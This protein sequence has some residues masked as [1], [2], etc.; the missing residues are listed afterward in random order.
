MRRLNSIYQGLILCLLLFLTPAG[1]TIAQTTTLVSNTGETARGNS[2]F[3]IGT[4]FTTGNNSTGY[5][6]SSVDIYI[7]SAAPVVTIRAN[8]TNPTGTV[9]AT[10]TKPAT[11]TN[12]A[13][14]TYTAPANTVLAA[15]TTYWLRVDATSSAVVGATS[16]NNETGATGW[17]IDNTS[18]DTSGSEY[19]Q[20]IRFAITGTANPPA[21]DAPTGLTATA[22][23]GQVTLSWENPNN[24]DITKYQ[25]HIRIGDTGANWRGWRTIGTSNANTTSH[26]VTGLTNGQVY[27]FVVRARTG[28]TNGPES[29]PYVF[30]T[31]VALPEITIAR[32][33][34][35]AVT[36][37]ANVVFRV[38]ASCTV[39]T[40]LTVNLL[41]AD[42]AGA[43]FISS[44]NEEAQTVT[45]K[46][47]S[48]TADFTLSTVGDAT[49]EPSLSVSLLLLAGT[50]Y[51]LGSL[52]TDFVKVNDDDPTTVILSIPDATALE[53]SSTDRATVRLT[54][55]RALRARERLAI[56]LGFSNGTL[57]TDFSLSLSGTP[58]GVA[59]S[60][61][62][63]TFSG[64]GSAMMAEVLLSASS[65]ADAAE[66]TITVSIPSSSSGMAPILTA[67]GLDGGATG[68]RTGN[69]QIVLN[70][71]D[72]PALV[73]LPEGDLLVNEGE[74][75][76][77]FVS[78]ATQPT[79]NVTV[80]VSSNNDDVTVDINGRNTITFTPSNWE[81]IRPVTFSGREDDDATN[82]SA[83]LSHSASGGGYGSVTGDL[84]VL[85]A[86]NDTPALVFS[87]MSLTVDEGAGGM[88]TVKLATQPTANVTVMVS[89]AGGEVTVDTNSGS[90]GDQ[91]ALTF[92]PSDWNSGKT[93]TVSAGED[94]DATNDSATL[95]HSASGGDYGSVTGDVMVTVTDNDTP[96]LVFS[97]TSLTLVE[98]ASNTYTVRL[99]TQPTGNVTVTV[100]GAGG[101]VTVDTDTGT[102]G[103][104][105]TLS[106]TSTT[107]NTAQTVTVSAGED[108]DTT[109][110]SATLSHST[111]G[112]D[113][114]SVMGDVMVTVTDN[115]APALVFSPTSLTVGEGASDTYTVRL[116]IRPTANVTVR[117]SG[118]GG[119]IT[120]D[121]DTGTNGNQ[122]TLSF[123][124]SDW[125]SE[126]TVTVSAGEDDDA[127]NDSA[128]LS[129]SASGGGYGSVTGDVM[130]TV[131]DND[132]PALVFS[133]TSLTVDEGAGGMYTVK[134]AT[135]P[136]ANVTVMVSG[137]SGEVTVDTDTGTDGNQNTLSFT[138]SDWNS[139]K[140]VTVS[141]GQDDDGANDGATLTH[142]A[143][144]GDYG[145]VTGDVVVT[146]TDND[147]P[148]LVF[149]ST[150]LTVVE[151][152]SN[153]YTVRLAT[154]PTGNVTV[155][156]SGASGEVTVDTNTGT[157]GN[158]NTL[159]F[160]TSDW[161][162]EK[163][164]TVSAGQD[165]DMDNDGA[166]LTH[167]ATGGDY[168]SVMGDVMVTVTDDDAPALA[169]SPTSLTVNE[170]ASVMYTVRLA[171]QPTDNVTVTV[172]STSGEVTVDTDTGTSG[173]Q[174]TLSFTTSD[175]NSGKMVTVSAGEDD[176]AANDSAT[177]THTAA[178]GDYGSVTGD[179]MVTV[180][181]NDVPALVLS[182]T[183]LTVDEG[184]SGM[185]TVKL[186]TQPTA[187]V[188]VMVSGAS[189]EVTVDTDT[190]TDGNQNTLSFTT[191]DWNSE[192]TVTVSA[193]QD[194][195]STDDEVTLTHT[196]AGG[197]YGAVMGDV[198]VTVTDNDTPALVFTPTSLTVG[199]GASNTYTVKLATQPTG[200]V[201]VRVS[202]ASGEVTVDTDTGTTGDQNTLSFTTS[203]WNRDK[204]V[205]VSAGQDEDMDNDSAT[206][207][208]SA[209]GGDYGSVTGDVM[210]TV[211]DDD[212][213]PNNAP[214]VMTMIPDQTATVGAAFNYQFPDNTFSDADNDPLDY[215]ATLSDDS[216]LPG[217]LA[218]AK[219]T[220]TFSG[221]PQ[222]SNVGTINIKVT[223]DDGNGSM[224]SDSFD[225]TVGEGD[226]LL[227]TVED[228]EKVVIF[229]NPS[230]RYLEVRSP[231]G[232]AF[233][234]LSLSGKSL[235]EGTTNTKV[236]ITSLRSGLYL[237]QLSDGRLLKFVRE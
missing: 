156:V 37:G 25:Y 180:T 229:P 83:T 151:G 176:D 111:S 31:P 185:Y 77:Y 166:T 22:C 26:T 164:V 87:S 76:T 232:S 167:T 130:I 219:T 8:G 88:Y 33:G 9:I 21:P 188:T 133:S 218:F 196:A 40:D 206:L 16:S 110:D 78:L 50:G 62:T 15:N 161:N 60:S 48:S 6:I 32:Q 84:D 91:N 44:I 209:S 236:D 24:A 7:L 69:G 112:G 174:N 95:T 205:T 148:A 169:F 45:I 14:N 30:A 187:N 192:K 222:A 237:V 137:A 75:G 178:G 160:T 66:E 227:G 149:S 132:T 98:G 107:W 139:E 38:T 39:T 73:F 223:A 68:S 155:M 106:F 42:A 2:G 56:P 34:S 18:R 67:T 193:G 46:S 163:T 215:S 190:G 144:G 41:A 181:D 51:T 114:G 158:Q 135:Q 154:E 122:N 171:T 103:N 104:Q 94:D 177:L 92:T 27:T 200:N 125:N 191:S 170:G 183:A 28:T 228:V 100:A 97:S 119:E 10:L 230:G 43:D 85:V 58:T 231:V 108:D 120:V 212:A 172:S 153:T 20:K 4:K 213:P 3:S 143:I 165:E 202:G 235:L 216:T 53:G 113:Y 136:T 211:T 189:G 207:T 96:A 128:T 117:V 186:A 35:A 195:D 19:T 63:V 138:T 179:V 182:P 162:S 150:S 89:G 131:T 52:R 201:T 127:A 199:E 54:L 101:E 29:S 49:D 145:S 157:N 140:T 203:D 105:N 214:T 23:N 129:H 109:N 159:S 142:T 86:D 116:T 146:V 141:A 115:D 123:T 71:D 121:T 224:V 226:A 65:D 81:G 233:K 152:A 204:T 61:N 225:I 1:K 12:F 175:W 47:G 234:I 217:W 102:D 126:K 124:T 80:T 36:E 220:R 118:A 11:I 55:N 99:A 70:D 90:P 59:L 210:V 208:H 198:V 147:T 72:T 93:V 173:N 79:G 184:T 82:D 5:T 197:D 74:A 134:L 57:G 64:G 168:G 17:S 221:T 13:I 194:D